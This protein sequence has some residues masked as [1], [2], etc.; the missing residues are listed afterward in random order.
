MNDE[1]LIKEK[2]EIIKNYV[3]HELNGLKTQIALETD[4]VKKSSTPSS[5]NKKTKPISK[6]EKH[7]KSYKK[8]NICSRIKKY[9]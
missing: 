1:K 6:L 7:K 3:Y 4:E 9:I 2:L 8:H 5:D